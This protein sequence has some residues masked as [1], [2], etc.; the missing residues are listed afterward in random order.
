MRKLSTKEK[1][2]QKT[3]GRGY[4]FQLSQP[5]GWMSKYL[6]LSSL[7]NP[8]QKREREIRVIKMG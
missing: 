8:Y 4:A 5:M 7:L 1:Q 6:S 3:S 2:K